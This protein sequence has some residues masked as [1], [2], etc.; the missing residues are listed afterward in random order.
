MY[1]QNALYM[2]SVVQSLPPLKTHWTCTKP[3]G[4]V[5]LDPLAS[6]ATGD[7]LSVQ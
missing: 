1:F 2:G 7:E 3:T 4:V 5:G 6:A